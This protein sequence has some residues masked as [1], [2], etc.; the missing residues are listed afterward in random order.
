MITQD[1]LP[2]LVNPSMNDI[3][4][5]EMLLVNRLSVA[6]HGMNVKE[7]TQVLQELLAHTITHFHD[8]E[9]L[10]QEDSFE[11]NSVHTAEHARHLHELKSLIKYFDKNQNPKAIIAYIDGNLEKWLLHH[12]ET[13]DAAVAHKHKTHN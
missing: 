12:I 6:A 11:E 13:M 1:Q 5:E 8:E 9:L 3:H 7:V 2:M 10:M 4:L